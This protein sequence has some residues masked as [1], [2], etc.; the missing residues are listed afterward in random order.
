MN[1]RLGISV[2]NMDIK[3]YNSKA[4]A[5]FLLEL[6]KYKRSQLMNTVCFQGD[7]ILNID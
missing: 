5:K 3:E 2:K 7:P 1:S 4:K 6:E